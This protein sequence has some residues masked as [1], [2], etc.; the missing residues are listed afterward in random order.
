M[1]KDDKS[2]WKKRV[3]DLENQAQATYDDRQRNGRVWGPSPVETVSRLEAAT[4]RRFEELT[5][6]GLPYREVLLV[7]GHD[8]KPLRETEAVAAARSFLRDAATGGNNILVLAGPVGVGKTVA[9]VY[10]A[11]TADPV[12]K[13]GMRWSES[14][15]PIFRHV[16]E[17]VAMGLYDDKEVRAQLAASKVTVLDDLGVEYQDKSG[18]YLSFLDWLLDRRYGSG[19]FTVL[20]TNLAAEKFREQYGERIYDRLRERAS[21][22]DI[23]HES[24]RGHA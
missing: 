5:R 17:L 1:E 21:W 13:F 23:V 16:T 24:L 12:L 4:R 6:W 20:T 3:A 22:C 8:Q 18:V 2:D 10:V 7:M 9:A 15:R 19:G 11:D 14:Q